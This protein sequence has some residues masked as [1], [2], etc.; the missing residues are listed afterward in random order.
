MQVSGF[1]IN[2]TKIA[3]DALFKATN[4]EIKVH[5]EENIPDQPVL[6]VIN[7]FTRMET[8][9][10]PYVIK[11]ITGKDVLSLAFK[12]LFGGGFGRFLERLGAIPTN[13]PDRDRIMIGALLKGDMP[14][15]IFPEGQMIKDKKLIEKGKF[16]VYNSGIRRPPHTGAAMIALRTE[17]YREKMRYYNEKGLTDELD[18]YLKHFEI[19][20]DKGIDDIIRQETIILPVNISYFPVRARENIINKI[21]NLFV[22][23]V[24]ERIEEELEVEGSMIIDGVDID[25]NFG[26]PIP[27]R[28]YLNRRSIIKKSQDNCKYLMDSEVKKGLHFR[29]EALS[30]MCRYMDSIY[31]MTTVNHDHVFSFILAK[32]KAN[33]IDEADFINRAYLAIDRMNKTEL[34]YC[35]SNLKLNQDSMLTDDGHRGYDSFIEA[36]KSDGLISVEDGYIIKNRDKFSNIYGFH[37]IRKDNIVEVLKNEIEPI[38]HLVR[39]INKLMWLPNF[40]VRKIIR[41]RFVKLDNDIFNRDYEKYYIEGETKP[42]EI[43]RPFFLK[44]PFGIYSRRG[45]ILIHGY[46]SAPEE[47]RELADYLYH[48]GHAVY[49]VRMRGHGTAPED[50]SQIQWNEW[51]DSVNRGYVVMKNTARKI[52]IVGFSTGAGLALLQAIRKRD[53]FCSVISINAPLKLNNIASNFA[54]VVVFWNELL[55]KIHIKKGKMDFVDNQPENPHINYFRNPVSGVRELEKVMDAVRKGLKELDVPTF[56]IQGI[57]DPIVNPESGQEIYDKIGTE[58]KELSRVYANRHVIV[59]GNG[60]HKIFAMVN[61]FL[62]N[63]FNS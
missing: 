50:L 20:S 41:D 2:L 54:S 30:L 13:A 14:C 22:D 11:K 4:A 39:D 59:R 55:E 19:E 49:G 21:A 53:R 37:S 52:A 18:A 48:T 60:S 24:S 10:L 26:N 27:I 17:F 40:I 7:H 6:Y 1:L 57:D 47:M 32:Y 46:M 8:F 38:R 44:R 45:V 58:R 63:H 36:A 56:I 28:P 34:E 16:M 15:L 61:E 23:N 25:I 29:K 51:Y 35:H 31:D 9:F 62:K 33:R 43:G 5:G 12:D 42:K 3:L